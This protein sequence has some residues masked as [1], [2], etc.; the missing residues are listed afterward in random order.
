MNDHDFE[1]TFGESESLDIS[2]DNE[3]ELDIDF[4]SSTKG[5]PGFSPVANVTRDG[6]EVIITITDESGT[7]QERIPVGETGTDDHTELI[8]RDAAEQHPE[9]AITGLEEDLLSRP[10]TAI[11]DADILNL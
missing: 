5:D 4:G 6:D 9:S 11:T 7:T 8:N 1:I 3:E 2:M 10:D